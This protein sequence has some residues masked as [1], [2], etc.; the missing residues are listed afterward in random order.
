[1]DFVQ[2]ITSLAEQFGWSVLQ[3]DSP[4]SVTIK[5]IDEKSGK[6]AP[7]Q[8]LMHT[9]DSGKT[10]IT[11][12]VSGFPLTY[13][14]LANFTDLLMRELM[15]RNRDLIFTRWELNEDEEYFAVRRT[16]ASGELK[17]DAFKEVVEEVASEA[18]EYWNL[19]VKPAVESGFQG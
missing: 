13:D 4:T 11:F 7:V 18:L 1:M 19:I 3:V 9:E 16:L 14:G 15:H 5:V 6:P 17:L 8:V 2:F 12:L 10:F